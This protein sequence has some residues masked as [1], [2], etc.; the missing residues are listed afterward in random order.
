M[1]FLA[2]KVAF[3]DGMPIWVAILYILCGL[4]IFLFG[5][6]MMG[7]ALKAIAGNKMKVIIE[8]ST[9][10]PIKGMFV[11]FMTTMLTQSASGT[12]ALAV[13][14]VA[15]GLMTFP[16]ALG[17][18]LGANI[19]GTILT[20]ILAAF[21]SFKIMPVVSV[22]LVFVGAALTFF[23]KKK[24]IKQI[25]SVILGF[26][27]IFL[28]LAFVD[29]SFKII[30]TEYDDMIKNLF[31]N[32]SDVPILG[33][34]FGTL[35]TFVVQ[36]SSA[37]IGIVQS[38]F[39]LG[40]VDLQGSFAIMLGANIGTTITALL[41]SL[42][43]SKQARKVAIANILI[44]FFGVIVFGIFFR[45]AY[46]PLFKLINEAFGWENNP[47]IISLGHLFFN[48]I[49]SFLFLG[50]LKPLAKLCDLMIKET[51]KDKK[52]EILADLLDY[53]LIKRSVPLALEF[54]KSSIMYMG[55]CVSEYVVISHSYSFER[56]DDLLEKGADLEKTINCLDKRIHDYLIKLTLGGLNKVQSRMLSKYLDQIKDLERVGDHC[57]NI[58]EFFEERY[59]KDYHLSDDG[60]QDLEQIYQVLLDMV[61][62]TLYAMAKWDKE[63]AQLAAKDEDEID[64][65]EEVFHERHVHRVSTGV[66]TVVNGEHYI[67]ILSNIE[68]M[69]DHLMNVCEGVLSE[70]YLQGE[71]QYNH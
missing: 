11:G 15:A 62:K 55:Q 10:T 60:N 45:W 38:M 27:F 71:A 4:G 8:K 61:E 19:G 18:L 6:D 37:T 21:S 16:Q 35:F 47:M 24:M 2:I 17:V 41:A 33:I 68:R 69:G 66:C 23:F 46:V 40:T 51:E 64:K 12:S 54:A 26:G 39:S 7:G 63:T 56:N 50:F 9:N 44:K 31:Q 48:I 3:A 52:E 53:S 70:E 57:T 20:I 13:S 59:E 30:L 22:I 32:L 28:G 36:S 65:L 43:S 25:G 58:L 5:I 49:N 29:M 42:G 67:E 1:D 14:L 34:I